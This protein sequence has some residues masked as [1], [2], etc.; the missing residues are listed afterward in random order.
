MLVKVIMLCSKI[1]LR[2]IYDEVIKTGNHTAQ[3]DQEIANAIN[4]SYKL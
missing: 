1:A 4:Y 3:I 2:N